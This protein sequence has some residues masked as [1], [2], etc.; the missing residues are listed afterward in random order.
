MEDPEGQFCARI[1]LLALL[2]RKLVCPAVSILECVFSEALC[3]VLLRCTNQCLATPV[4]SS[5]RPLS[6][7]TSLGT[8][9]G[10]PTWVPT[11]TKRLGNVPSPGLHASQLHSKQHSY[12]VSN[13]V[14]V[15]GGDCHGLSGL[16]V[17]PAGVGT[18]EFKK[19]V[20]SPGPQNGMDVSVSPAVAWSQSRGGYS[21]DAVLSSALS[22]AEA[23][24]KLCQ[25]QC[26]HPDVTI[27]IRHGFQLQGAH[28]YSRQRT[29]QLQP[30]TGNHNR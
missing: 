22:G 24:M 9:A 21:Q 16:A 27:A 8:Q 25:Q 12:T 2:L 20:M 17:S 5:L 23:D 4:S 18:P 10:V 29:Q 14:S 7:S 30:T 15:V 3:P 19:L 6:S 28:R 26:Q 13:T 11:G 1:P